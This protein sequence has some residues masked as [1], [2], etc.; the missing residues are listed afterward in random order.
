LTYASAEGFLE[1]IGKPL[2]IWIKGLSKLRFSREKKA[3]VV[4]K[5]QSQLRQA[6]PW[7]LPGLIGLS[8]IAIFP[9]MYQGAIALTDFNAV[10]IKDGIQ[11]GIGRA[12]WGGLTGQ[13]EA[14]EFN[15][16]DF[17]NNPPKTVSYTGPG[18][19]FRLISGGMSEI[20][21]FNVMWTV[22]SII[23]QGILG[24]L[25]A[26][27]LNQ[28]NVRFTNFW[29]TIFIL[30]WS[31]PEFVGALV[32][33]RFFEPDTGWL[34]LTQQLPAGVDIPNWSNN[35]LST[36]IVLMI[37]A[38]WYGFPIIFLA[39]TAGLKLIP[40]DVY[41]AAAIDGA[42]YWTSFRYVTWPLLLPLLAP[43]LIIRG[44]FAFN[45]FY[46]FYTFQPPYP[47]FTFATLSYYFFMPTGFLGGQF[48]VSAVIN[49]ITVIVLI[50]LISLF[51]R[52]SKA[53][54]VATYA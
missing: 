6:I 10:S 32:W 51:N 39:A 16:F 27:A 35:P 52:W 37:A 9:L 46:L 19:F 4:V 40:K 2:F 30:P 1:K 11:G 28:P 42:G 14:V 22:L 36:L 47:L 33:L 7:L 3:L 29:R 31:I 21:V 44:I 17:N 26:L 38:T 53:A 23:L 25:V 18:L 50:A 48:S 12:V 34:A 41:D 20:L 49:I 45:Q 13:E 15:P 24:I 54:E 5:E 43:A 8:V